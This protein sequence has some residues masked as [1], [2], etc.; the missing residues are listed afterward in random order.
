MIIVNLLVIVAANDINYKCRFLFCLSSLWCRL[1]YEADSPHQNIKVLHST[2]FGNVLILDN[3]ISKYC[4]HVHY[5]LVPA[6]Y[7]V[8]FEFLWLV[9]PW[10]CHSRNEFICWPCH[11]CNTCRGPS[12]NWHPKG[13]GGGLSS[14][15]S[16][17]GCCLSYWC[18]LQILVSLR[19]SAIFLAMRVSF[20][21]A[22]QGIRLSVFPVKY[23]DTLARRGICWLLNY[24]IL[25]MDKWDPKEPNQTASR[26]IL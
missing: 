8:L 10:W 15:R 1:I 11:T 5:I 2:Q 20:R 26:T 7:L 18:K 21:V 4:I 13:G 14:E 9:I 3:D 16:G 24:R 19:I 22:P 25:F 6:A 12:T 23:S 17:D